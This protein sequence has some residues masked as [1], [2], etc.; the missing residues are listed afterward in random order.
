LF[1]SPLIEEVPVFHSKAGASLAAVVALMTSAC[2]D[3]EPAAPATQDVANP[4]YLYTNGPITPGVFRTAEAF[5]FG[6]PDFETG[7]LAW[8][9]FPDDPTDAV[10]CGGDSDYPLVPL[11]AAGLQQEV[12]KVLGVAKEINIHVYDLNNFED[13]CFSPVIAAGTGHAVYTDNDFFNTGTG[14]N[15]FGLDI[16]GILTSVPGGEP[17][18]VRGTTRLLNMPDGSFRV[19]TSHLSLTPVGGQ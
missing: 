11:Q 7:L 2:G 9:G 5:V 19:G 1:L 18:R 6:L 3:N 15:A 17:V 16:E 14:A 8:V 4:Q 10:D 13:T 12:L